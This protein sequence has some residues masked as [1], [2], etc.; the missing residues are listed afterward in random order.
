[1]AKPN[2]FDGMMHEFC[3]EQGWCGS[4]VD[5]KA[6]HVTDFIPENGPV[7]AD[8]FVDWLIKADGLDPGEG[9]SQVKRWKSKLKVIFIKHMGSDCIEASTLAWDY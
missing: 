5:G 8:E 3:V 1:M 2:K 4:I 6:L 9:S 7:T